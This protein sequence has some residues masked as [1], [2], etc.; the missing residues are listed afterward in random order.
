VARRPFAGDRLVVATHN[1]GKLAE[2][3][4]LLPAGVTP[5]SAGELG[6][7]EPV[8]DGRSFAENALI[9]ARAA[10]LAAGLPA[11][12]D[13]SGLV[14]AGLDG[15]PGIE[16][17]RWAGPGRDFRAAMRRVHDGLG[18]RFGAFEAA[19]RRAAFVAAL[20]LYWPEGDGHHE[21]VEGRVDGLL[22]WPPRGAGGFGYDPMFAPAG[23]DGRTFAEMDPAE[24][25][26]LSHRGRALR[27]LVEA[28]FRSWPAPPPGGR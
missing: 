15:A 19:D 5:V 28:C 3:R 24:K 25:H 11:V 1:P 21:A 7:P 12:A 26:A 27:A 9:K 8:E 18:A 14:V 10:A 22:V 20:C 23:G 13:D 6:L 16:S 2:F 17:A 4:D